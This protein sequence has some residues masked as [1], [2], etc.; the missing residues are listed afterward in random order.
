[1][2]R[3]WRSGAFGEPGRFPNSRRR[4]S[5]RFHGRGRRR[6]DRAVSPS[7]REPAKSGTLGR[8]RNSRDDCR[9][10]CIRRLDR[11]RRHGLVPSTPSSTNLRY[12]TVPAASTNP[13][14]TGEPDP[15]PVRGPTILLLG[16][17]PGFWRLEG[18]D[19]VDRGELLEVRRRRRG[20]RA[21]VK[22]LKHARAI[23]TLEVPE[24][25]RNTRGWCRTRA[26]PRSLVRSG[27]GAGPG[28]RTARSP[29]EAAGRGAARARPSS[30]HRTSRLR[31]SAAISI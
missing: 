19:R 7:G 25:A 11:H 8:R 14:H 2:P 12:A 26:W 6:F 17:R 1:M 5:G 31:P 13:A 15:A 3:L 22:R 28:A 24:R 10:D 20:R 23:R 29:P 21:S 27:A 18:C 9:A 4:R 30:R 16:S